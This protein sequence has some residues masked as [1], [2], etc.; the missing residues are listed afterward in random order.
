MIQKTRFLY[1]LRFVFHAVLT[2]YFI[3]ISSKCY[4]DTRSVQSHTEAYKQRV[5]SQLVSL[6]LSLSRTEQEPVLA[7]HALS[8]SY[9][10]EKG[11]GIHLNSDANS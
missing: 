5:I 9:S 10:G 6:S 4:A 7:V 2:S 1:N 8:L 11:E 3:H